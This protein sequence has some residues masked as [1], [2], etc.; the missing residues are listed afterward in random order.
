MHIFHH[1]ILFGD[2]IW[3]VHLF[4]NSLTGLDYD[5]IALNKTVREEKFKMNWLK[6]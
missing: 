3:Q 2:I 1:I 6:H 4:C 5:F